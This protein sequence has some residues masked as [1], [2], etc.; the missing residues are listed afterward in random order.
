MTWTLCCLI[1]MFDQQV[2]NNELEV[3]VRLCSLEVSSVSPMH[4]GNQQLMKL[5]PN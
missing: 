1:G 5:G 3:F 4:G 2:R